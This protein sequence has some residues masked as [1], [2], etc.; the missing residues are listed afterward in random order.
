MP[1]CQQR[2]RQAK[3]VRTAQHEEH[4]KRQ[5]LNP[6]PLFPNPYDAAIITLPECSLGRLRAKYR[7][8]QTVKDVITPQLQRI[9]EANQFQRISASAQ[10]TLIKGFDNGIIVRDGAGRSGPSG[11]TTGTVARTERYFTRFKTKD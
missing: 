3:A 11:V 6:P 8:K 1:S 9:Y 7:P 5:K 10:H 4:N 2:K